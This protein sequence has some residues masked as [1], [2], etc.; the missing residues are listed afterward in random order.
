MWRHYL[1]GKKITLMT[2]H[3]SLKYFFSQTYLNARQARWLSFLSE[4]DIDI[5]HIKQKE[6]KII[7]ALIRNSF[8]NIR[9]IGSSA[10][11]DLEELVKKV[12]YQD[13]NYENLQLK[14]LKKEMVEYTQNQKGLICYKNRLYIPNVESSKK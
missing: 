9:N 5:K 1:L 8:Q 12:V 14:M 11:L 6:K 7:D 10:S 3:I 4:F 2:D 13:P